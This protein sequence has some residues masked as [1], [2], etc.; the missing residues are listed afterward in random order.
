MAA[1]QIS[2]EPVAVYLH[3][4]I[5]AAAANPPSQHS[6]GN[7]EHSRCSWPTPGQWPDQQQS[8]AEPAEADFMETRPEL[9]ATRRHSSRKIVSCSLSKLEYVRCRPDGLP[10]VGQ[11]G[12]SLYHDWMLRTVGDLAL[13]TINRFVPSWTFSWLKGESDR[14]RKTMVCPTCRMKSWPAV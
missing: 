7:Q 5:V 10:S 1:G 2:F 3:P 4:Q 14:P 11:S 13:R 9:R 8:A 12:D 6:D